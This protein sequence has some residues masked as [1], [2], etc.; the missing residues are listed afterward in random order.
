LKAVE[1]RNLVKRFGGGLL[2]RGLTVLD[3]VSF[4]VDEG[5]HVAVV[6]PPSSGKLVLLKVLSAMYRP[7][8]GTV[9]VYGHDVAKEPRRV[10]ELTSLVCRS[11]RF[12]ERLTLKE[13]LRFV[14]SA[15]GKR[16]EDVLA[17]LRELGFREP[18]GKPIAVLPEDLKDLVRLAIGLMKRPK[19]LLLHKALEMLDVETKE[20]VVEYLEREAEGLTYIMV[21]NDPNVA[22]RLCDYVL[23]LGPEGRMLRFC[24][25]NELIASFPYKFTVKVFFKPKK[26]ASLAWA[27][28]YPHRM[29]G[30]ALVLH[31]SS[32]DEVAELSSLLSRAPD[33]LYFEVSRAGMEDIYLWVLDEG[34]SRE[35]FDAIYTEL[36]FTSQASS[37]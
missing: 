18:I 31:L 23:I 12:H 13:T 9:K 17:L 34:C 7:T 36:S 1:V 14:A 3:G 27:S 22:A 16:F 4:E 29:I 25:L 26:A 21:E 2:R 6:G 5:S 11:L 33:I 20:R 30:E 35:A 28:S 32:E 24:P 8:S 15:Q 37:L 19:L 10:Q